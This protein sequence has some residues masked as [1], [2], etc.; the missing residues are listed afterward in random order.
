M[1]YYV[2]S[3]VDAECSYKFFSKLLFVCTTGISSAHTVHCN[4]A[5]NKLSVE[6]KWVNNL[7][8]IYSTAE[9]KGNKAIQVRIKGFFWKCFLGPNDSSV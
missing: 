8:Q 2:Q 1:A 9:F 5:L 4:W 6:A 3:L 7:C